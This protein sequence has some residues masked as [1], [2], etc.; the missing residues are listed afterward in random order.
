MIQMI[1]QTAMYD[2]EAIEEEQKLNNSLHWLL[3]TA[4]YAQVVG[5]ILKAISAD[6]IVGAFTLGMCG[7]TAFAEL[8]H[9]NKHQESINEDGT[10]SSS[11]RD[12]DKIFTDWVRRWLNKGQL[13][14]PYDSLKVYATRCALVHSY[15]WANKLKKAEIDGYLLTRD[16]PA[17]HCNL[18]KVNDEK[19]IYRLNLENFIAD[20]IFAFDDCFQNLIQNKNDGFLNYAKALIVAKRLDASEQFVIVDRRYIS[21]DW[22]DNRLKES[23]LHVT[24]R[25]I[26]EKIANLKRGEPNTI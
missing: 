23:P 9:W 17:F 24:K 15:G 26:I 21:L 14:E 20:L 5:D 25:E 4:F 16:Q 10:L 13:D 6:A 18:K 22:F 12:N 3:R 19:W 2:P 7:I 1:S 11:L 8:E